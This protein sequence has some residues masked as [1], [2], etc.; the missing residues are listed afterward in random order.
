MKKYIFVTALL[1]SSLFTAKAQDV[2]ANDDD[3]NTRQEKI[4]AL[5]V[6]YV[7]KELN[8]S[9]ED[10]QK[11]WPVHTQFQNEL[12]TVNKDLPEL[13]KQQARLNIRK[14]YHENFNRI[15]GPQRCERFYK[16]DGEFKRKL[17]ESIRNRKGNQQRPRMRKGL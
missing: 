14:K 6:A 17:L 7:T 12:K 15:L 2:H 16:M 4:Q 1:I 8:L 11:F 9:P 13:D 5:Y 3:N 10:A